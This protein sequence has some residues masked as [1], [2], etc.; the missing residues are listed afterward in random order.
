MD[1][2]SGR[3]LGKER[4]KVVGLLLPVATDRK[5]KVWLPVASEQ[6]SFTEVD[7]SGS[8]LSRGPR[9]GRAVRSCRSPL[10]TSTKAKK[11]IKSIFQKAVDNGS[12]CTAPLPGRNTGVLLV[13]AKL[14]SGSVFVVVCFCGG[15]F[16]GGSTKGPFEGP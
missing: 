6:G 15:F 11:I 13:I 3:L 1:R 10:L 5:I 9:E 12:G 4:L 16:V 8:E 2:D 14:G 7:S